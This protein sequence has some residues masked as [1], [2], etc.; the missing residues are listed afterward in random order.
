MDKKLHAIANLLFETGMLK[1]TERTGLAFLGSGRESVA[2]HAFRVT[3]IAYVLAKMEEG[4]DEGRLIKMCLLHDLVEART[5][6]HNYVQK[7]YVTVD[8][9]KALNDIADSVFFGNDIRDLVNEFN[10]GRT[11]ESFLA[12]DAD[13]LEL[14]LMLKE[15][16]D[17]G[18]PYADEWIAYALKR[19]KTETAKKLAETILCTDSTSWWFNEKGDWWVSGGN[20]RLM[21]P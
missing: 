8:E 20:P 1:K 4:V 3:M 5:G 12:N 21:N 14:I 2:E 18:N 9:E 11:I 17:L 7:K 6:D 19:L 10:S 16:K 13:Q 15:N